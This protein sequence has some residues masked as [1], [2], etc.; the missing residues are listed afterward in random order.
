[1]NEQNT[2]LASDTCVAVKS[3]P[4]LKYVRAWRHVFLI[5]SVERVTPGAGQIQSVVVTGVRMNRRNKPRR[6]LEQHRIVAR[7]AISP[8]QYHF[9]RR[10]RTELL[11]IQLW[12]Q[13]CLS[14]HATAS[15]ASSAAASRI[16]TSRVICDSYV[17][18]CDPATR[19]GQS[20]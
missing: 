8:Q 9:D 13:R 18:A 3:H 19:L 6:H 14:Y 4:Q 15:A 1:M 12:Q 7:V 10:P 11:P 16:R 5:A 20:V 17:P 2:I